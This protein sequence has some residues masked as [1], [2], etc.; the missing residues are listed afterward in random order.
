MARTATSRAERQLEHLSGEL[1]AHWHE[2][3]HLLLSR[4]L[5][6]SLYRRVAG[7][8]PPVQLQALAALGAGD[9]R[10]SELAARLGL[11]VSTVTRL[12]DR[13]EAAGLAERR[14]HRPD[15]RSVLVGLS[16]AGREALQT[17]RTKLRAL[18]D[19]LL[20]EL[21]PHERRELVRLLTKL[22]GS[23]RP[24]PPALSAASA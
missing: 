20:A 13:L 7:E 8:I 3:A 22:L 21:P 24:Q 23:L 14:S 17:I 12:V 16:A 9:L 2:L 18:L 10:I 11:A 19:E 5:T 6:A 15:R 1:L 4:R